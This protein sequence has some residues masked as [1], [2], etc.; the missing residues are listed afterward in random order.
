MFSG[1]GTVQ[2]R[3]PMPISLLSDS[4]DGCLGQD[5][6]SPAGSR[7]GAPER[8]TQKTPVTP[9]A[10]RLIHRINGGPFIIAKFVAQDS[11]P[12]FRLE[13]RLGQ[14]HQ[15]ATPHNGATNVLNSLSAA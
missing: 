13:S 12:R 8:K 11:K 7:R 4:K 6:R 2:A 14:R 9:N 10:M 5:R 15:P 3:Q 1:C